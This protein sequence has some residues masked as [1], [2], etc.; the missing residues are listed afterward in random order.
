MFNCHNTIA[1]CTG[2]QGIAH[3]HLQPFWASYIESLLHLN[4]VLSLEYPTS[5]VGWIMT[6][7]SFFND[8]VVSIDWGKLDRRIG[9]VWHIQW[10]SE[11]PTNLVFKW[12]KVVCSPNCLLSKYHLNTGVNLVW[13]SDHHLN[14]GHLNN[15]QV[16]VCYSDVRYSDPHCR[17]QNICDQVSGTK[18]VYFFRPSYPPPL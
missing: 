14:T 2:I 4:C 3:I 5:E 7:Y 9:D 18:I 17:R 16:K 10:G 8:L 15:R 13:Y 6:S 11:Y 1:V 12:S